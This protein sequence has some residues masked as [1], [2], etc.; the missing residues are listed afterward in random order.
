M[1]ML[2]LRCAVLRLKWEWAGL[3]H[4]LRKHPA[5]R[6]VWWLTG[7]PAMALLTVLDLVNAVLEDL[8]APGD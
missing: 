3:W 2:F 7:P 1:S 6:W 8:G 5:K 4:D